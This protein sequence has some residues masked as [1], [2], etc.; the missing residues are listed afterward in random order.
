[1]V[2]A[3]G[4]TQVTAP[5]EFTGDILLK[6]CLVLVAHAGLLRSTRALGQIA[7][8][9]SLV[10]T[11]TDASGRVFPGAAVTAVNTDTKDTYRTYGPSRVPADRGIRADQFYSIQL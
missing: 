1:M 5:P 9:T 7:T 6:I 8:T 2:D 3:A 4:R 10:G 11:V